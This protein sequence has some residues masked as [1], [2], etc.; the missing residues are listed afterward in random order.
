MGRHFTQPQD[1]QQNNQ[2]VS[3]GHGDTLFRPP[4]DFPAP[5]SRSIF[6]NHYTTCRVSC[7]IVRS[8][9]ATYYSVACTCFGP[10]TR[11]N[12]ENCSP[13]SSTNL[14]SPRAL[15]ISQR[16]S[17]ASSNTTIS[18]C[19]RTHPRQAISRHCWRYGATTIPH[20]RSRTGGCSTAQQSIKSWISGLH[21]EGNTIC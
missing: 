4:S 20:A 19:E 12:E 7:G 14:D 3:P 8:L 18:L 21:A 10:S 5:K 17:S 9:T 2:K 6:P 15:R 11:P 13:A 16:A 1:A